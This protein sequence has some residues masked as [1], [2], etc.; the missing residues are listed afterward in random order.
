MQWPVYAHVPRIP[1]RDGFLHDNVEAIH[2]AASADI[3]VGEK[4]AKPDTKPEFWLVVLETFSEGRLQKRE[5]D[6]VEGRVHEVTG[7]SD[8]VEENT[9]FV[10]ATCRNYEALIDERRAGKTGE[11]GPLG[12]YDT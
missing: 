3:R 4:V 7:W 9:G 8:P 10:E 6:R 12:R 2:Y 5:A 1:P 11:A